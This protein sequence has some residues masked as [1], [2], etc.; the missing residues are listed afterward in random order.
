MRLKR[1]VS[2]LD[3]C[4]CGHTLLSHE[5]EGCCPIVGWGI[6]KPCC[7]KGCMEFKLDNLKY[8]ER[9]SDNKSL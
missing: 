2:E 8:L 9:M 7:P 6:Q 4:T 5:P 1:N 3:F